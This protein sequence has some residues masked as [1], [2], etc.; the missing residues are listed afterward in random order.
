[1]EKNRPSSAISGTAVMSIITPIFAGGDDHD[2]QRCKKNDD[3][4]CNKD[5]DKQKNHAKIECEIENKNK[6]RR[7]R[8]RLGVC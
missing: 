7:Q 1:V 3:N 2:G 4:N 5:I 8:Q 6:E